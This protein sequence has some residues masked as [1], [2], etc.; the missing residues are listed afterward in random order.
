MPESFTSP[1]SLGSLKSQHEISK[2]SRRTM[3]TLGVFWVILLCADVV[4][5]VSV[6]MISYRETKNPLSALVVPLICVGIFVLPGAILLYQQ[7][8]A[9][10]FGVAFYDLGTAIRTR[11]GVIEIRWRDIDALWLE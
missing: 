2:N 9:G 11:H 6:F 1:S 7:W 5:S 10:V 3:M 8:W 4:V